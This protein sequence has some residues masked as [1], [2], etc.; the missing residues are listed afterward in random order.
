MNT[1]RPQTNFDMGQGGGAERMRT[2]DVN[3]L[4]APGFYLSSAKDSHPR[5]PK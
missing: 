1:K 3:L 5:T 4:Q 2:V